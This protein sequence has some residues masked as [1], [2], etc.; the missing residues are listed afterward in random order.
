MVG[1]DS[2]RL[3]L[4]GMEAVG[5]CNC[6]AGFGGHSSS[7]GNGIVQAAGTEQRIDSWLLHLTQNRYPL[8][9]VFLYQNGDLRV[10]EEAAIR[11]PLPDQ[12]FRLEDREACNMR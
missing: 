11:Q 6:I 7:S 3:W 10:V 1:R 4:P 8:S 12:L 5:D 9:R 2:D